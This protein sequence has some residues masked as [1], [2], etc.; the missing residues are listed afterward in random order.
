MGSTRHVHHWLVAGLVVALVGC[1]GA[2]DDSAGGEA[3]ATIAAVAETTS[4]AGR[5]TDQAAGG[6]AAPS[7]EVAGG[8]SSEGIVAPDAQVPGQAIAIEA[9][10]TLQVDD[11]RA[12]VERL[13]TAVIT[14]GGRVAA[15]DVDYD[16]QPVV[17]ET[18]DDTDDVD[19]SRATLVLSLPPGE[20]PSMAEALAEIGTVTSFDQLA[21][22]VTEQLAD[23]ESRIDNMRASVE[24][25]RALLAEA[26]DID[27]IVRL[28]AELTSRETELERLL[29]AQRQLDDRVAM[30]TLTVVVA[31]T[32]PAAA[33]EEAEDD[34]GVVDALAAGWNAFTTG[35]FT[36]ALVL[37]AIAPFVA[38]AALLAALA[39]LSRRAVIR[40]RPPVQPP[41]VP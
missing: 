37:A 23:V 30:S 31:T 19:D 41:L 8:D 24:R 17:D 4:G 35:L 40:R 25:V 12:T 13:T 36:V 7:A 11:V 16:P 5:D 2:D 38:A 26:V 6:A 34:P 21:E 10:A 28:E 29:A 33:T 1:T 20:L 39:L 27:G 22:D 3:A 9:H 15:A 14:R 32:P 18:G